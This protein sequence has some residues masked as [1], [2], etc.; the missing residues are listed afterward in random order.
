MGAGFFN[1]NLIFFDFLDLC[2]D[3]PESVGDDR[4]A[5]RLEDGVEG[6]ID[7]EAGK[8]RGIGVS[9]VAVMLALVGEVVRDGVVVVCDNNGDGFVEP[10]T[11][12][13]V[14]VGYNRL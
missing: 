8:L 10:I 1:E 7:E 2:D 13:V 12:G 5:G 9:R 14:A 11:G 4:V 6:V 3:A